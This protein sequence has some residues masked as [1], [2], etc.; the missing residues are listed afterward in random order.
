MSTTDNGE[1]MV[2]AISVN[3][4]IRLFVERD[5]MRSFVLVIVFDVKLEA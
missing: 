5:Q 3:D 4:L 1:E 2:D